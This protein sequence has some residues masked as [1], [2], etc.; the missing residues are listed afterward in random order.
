MLHVTRRSLVLKYCVYTYWPYIPLALTSQA[1]WGNGSYLVYAC[2]FI[3]YC[4]EMFVCSKLNILRNP[5]KSGDG[6]AVYISKVAAVTV[7]QFADANYT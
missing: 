3:Q 6:L 7:T 5:I 4:C 2:I 1:D